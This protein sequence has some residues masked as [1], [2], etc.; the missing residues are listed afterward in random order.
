[1]AAA[2]V[3]WRVARRRGHAPP[4]TPAAAGPVEQPATSTAPPSESGT[5]DPPAATAAVQIE[6]DERRIPV[7]RD[8]SKPAG[9]RFLVQTADG[10]LSV[11]RYAAGLLRE[12][13]STVHTTGNAFWKRL[14]SVVAVDEL[15]GLQGLDSIGGAMM[16]MR[17]PT[18]LSRTVGVARMET[19]QRNL[20][21]VGSFDALVVENWPEFVLCNPGFR[22]GFL[23]PDA[24]RDRLLAVVRELESALSAAQLAGILERIYRM[25]GR[26]VHGFPDLL[27]ID[28]EGATLIAI[29]PPG[30][31][32]D[33]AKMSLLSELGGELGVPTALLVFEEA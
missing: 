11:E 16:Q 17:S 30:Q 14:A 21:R 5:P 29:Q 12:E 27:V 20:R 25:S 22:T 8:T 6:I 26:R 23:D 3:G 24:E 10:P 32:P 1:V 2:A 13:G 19:F 15:K 7:Q 9:G 28:G 4:P 31:A 33:A 18:E